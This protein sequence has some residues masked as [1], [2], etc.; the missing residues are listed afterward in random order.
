MNSL[1]WFQVY[2]WKNTGDALVY[3]NAKATLQDR[4]VIT[5]GDYGLFEVS[6]DDS[7][8]LYELLHLITY[9]DLTPRDCTL[10]R[11]LYANGWK[12][13]VMLGMFWI[14]RNYFYHATW[15][16]QFFRIYF[17]WGFSS[18]LQLYSRQAIDEPIEPT[19]RM[20]AEMK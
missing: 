3:D 13:D 7:G 1:D 14:K 9:Y 16:T 17:V 6:Y 8:K 4:I 5:I 15:D 11:I 10:I 18:M 19:I 2:K 20:I 12:Y